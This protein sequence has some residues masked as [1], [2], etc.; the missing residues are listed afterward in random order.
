MSIRMSIATVKVEDAAMKSRLAG[1]QE[2]I[3]Q[4][5]GTAALA[6]SFYTP[7]PPREKIQNSQVP[8]PVFFAKLNGMG[9]GTDYHIAFC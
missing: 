5:T 3:L 9:G 2:E 4:A 7:P 6:R 8:S 1:L